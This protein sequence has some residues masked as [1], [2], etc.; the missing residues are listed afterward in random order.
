VSRIFYAG[1]MLNQEIEAVSDLAIE[2]IYYFATVKYV[3]TIS[4]A[5]SLELKT[6]IIG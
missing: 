3:D 5:I 2:L 1:L 6:H 4:I